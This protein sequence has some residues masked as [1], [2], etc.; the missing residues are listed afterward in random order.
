MELAKLGHTVTGID[1]S[2]NMIKIA[3]SYRSKFAKK[4]IDHSSFQIGS[5]KSNKLNNSQFDLCIAMGV[6]G[7]LSSDKII[8]QL[9]KK[10]T[11]K[12]GM[13]LVSLETDYL[14]CRA[15]FR[16]LAEKKKKINL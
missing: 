15:P 13:F 7:Y 6:I 1:Q 3:N 16:T 9:M 14:T 5:I 8:F 11:K 10:I 4:A 12:N 2:E